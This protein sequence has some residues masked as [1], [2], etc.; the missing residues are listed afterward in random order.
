M[1]ITRDMQPN[2]IHDMPV[3]S[4]D[5]MYTHQSYKLLHGDKKKRDT[6]RNI[7]GWTAKL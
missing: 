5:M 3:Y 2:R 7:S 6:K 4:R 1:K